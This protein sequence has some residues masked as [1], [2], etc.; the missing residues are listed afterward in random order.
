[1]PKMANVLIESNG[2]WHITWA[3]PNKPMGAL[4]L[5]IELNTILDTLKVNAPMGFGMV[6]VNT[7]ECGSHTWR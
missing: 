7:N 1:M 6:L 2:A 3:T 4:D 5:K